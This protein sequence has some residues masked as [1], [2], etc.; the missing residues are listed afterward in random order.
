[1]SPPSQE[2]PQ[3]LTAAQVNAWMY[4][5][6]LKRRQLLLHGTDPA[7][8]VQEQAF[9]EMGE[10]CL[11]ALEEVRVVSEQLWEVS[12]AARFRSTE[13]VAESARLLAQYTSATESLILQI[14]SGK[15]D[16]EKR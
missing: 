4:R 10:L 8:D 1:M 13:I 9:Q 12:E 16:T 5:T 6:S 15:K 3:P 14:F 2:P 11:D 7:S